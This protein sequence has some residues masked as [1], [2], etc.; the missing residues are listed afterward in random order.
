MCIPSENDSDVIKTEYSRP[1]YSERN[2]EHD[3]TQGL[4]IEESPQEEQILIH[5]NATEKEQHSSTGD[6]RHDEQNVN[7]ISLADDL[8]RA[9]LE[10]DH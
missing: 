3:N 5:S 9:F 1:E 10:H 7:R 4:L 6:D 8:V 2:E